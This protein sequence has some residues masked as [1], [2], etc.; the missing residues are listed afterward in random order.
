[1]AARVEILIFRRL[2]HSLQVKLWPIQSLIAVIK[3][4]GVKTKILRHKEAYL[5]LNKPTRFTRSVI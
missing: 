3:E 1:M 5:M 2:L 4:I